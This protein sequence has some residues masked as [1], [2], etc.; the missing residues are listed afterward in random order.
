MNTLQL[1]AHSGATYRQIDT[2]STKGLLPTEMQNPGTG[3]ARE[4]TRAQADRA[5]L[6]FDLIDTGIG[7]QRAAAIADQAETGGFP[8]ELP[9]GFRL[10]RTTQQALVAEVVPRHLRAITA[11]S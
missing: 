6:I 5:K 8:V 1:M 10:E 2:W 9:N 7:L 3:H 11:G 4:W